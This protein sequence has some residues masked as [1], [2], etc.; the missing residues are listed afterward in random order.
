MQPLRRTLIVLAVAL[1]LVAPTACGDGEPTTGAAPATSAR[2]GGAGEGAS[3]SSAATV[4]VTIT[5]FA[6]EPATIRVEPGT[7]V[8]FE[9]ADDTDHTATAD[10]GAV[11]TDTIARGESVSVVVDQPGTHAYHCGFHP[12]MKGVVEVVAA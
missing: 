9:N 7:T 8:V 4:R 6:F 10:D 3:A 2:A 12:F 11:D 1:A 5:D